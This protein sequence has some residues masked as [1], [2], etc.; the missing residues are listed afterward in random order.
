MFVLT[1]FSTKR[2]KL[3]MSHIIFEYTLFYKLS[4]IGIPEILLIVV[5]CCG[6]FQ[7]KNSTLI[8]TCRSKLVSYFLY[9]VFLIF[10]HYFQS[11][12]NTTLRVK[13]HIYVSYTLS[14]S[15]IVLMTGL[16][17]LL[18]N[19]IVLCWVPKKTP[20]YDGASWVSCHFFK[21]NML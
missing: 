11:L 5:F 17:V 13:Q 14:I 18:V 3:S 4:Y 1:I 6:F 10:N 2:I 20:I 12:K 21:R 8:L 16:I 19:V 7:G 15:S 9:K